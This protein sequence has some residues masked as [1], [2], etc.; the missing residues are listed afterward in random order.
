MIYTLPTPIHKQTNSWICL[1]L[2][3]AN[4]SRTFHNPSLTPGNV[5]SAQYVEVAVSSRILYFLLQLVWSDWGYCH[6]CQWRFRNAQFV[7][8]R[9]ELSSDLGQR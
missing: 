6:L 9:F 7:G 1:G 2:F 8:I 4:L 3:L 5:V